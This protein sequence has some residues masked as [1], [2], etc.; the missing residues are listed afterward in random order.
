MN[1]VLRL[2]VRPEVMPEAMPGPVG[3]TT[4]EDRRAA[5]TRRLVDMIHQMPR[6]RMEKVLCMR[7]L[8]ARNGLET[9]ERIDGTVQRLLEEYSCQTGTA[10]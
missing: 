7:R 4:A 2:E 5:E 6:I 10:N 8:I 3:A 1:D 9:P